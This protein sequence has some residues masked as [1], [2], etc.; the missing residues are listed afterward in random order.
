MPQTGDGSET[1]SRVVV[2]MGDPVSHSRQLEA[3]DIARLG[4]GCDEDNYIVKVV[5]RE[6]RLLC[7]P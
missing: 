5:Q 2:L 6:T 7:K 1:K 4:V 3:N